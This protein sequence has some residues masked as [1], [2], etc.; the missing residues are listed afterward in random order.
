MQNNVSEWPI[1]IP[2]YNVINLNCFQVQN[3]NQIL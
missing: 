2:L 3:I 1:G